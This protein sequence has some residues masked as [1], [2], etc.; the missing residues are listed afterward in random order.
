MRKVSGSTPLASTTITIVGSMSEISLQQAKTRPLPLNQFLT[1]DIK[2]D[3]I[4]SGI[5]L[6]QESFEYEFTRQIDSK[7]KGHTIVFA[8][9]NIKELP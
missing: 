4:F 3:I 1:S 7:L 9:P 8:N 6:K 2:F 5:R